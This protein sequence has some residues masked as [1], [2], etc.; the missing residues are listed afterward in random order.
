MNNRI[1]PGNLWQTTYMDG[2]V[3]V[4]RYV[5]E[6]KAMDVKTSYSLKPVKATK[7]WYADNVCRTTFMHKSNTLEVEF[8]SGLVYQYFDVPVILWKRMTEAVSVG[9]FMNIHLK[10]NYRYFRVR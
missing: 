9:S 1:M 6:H 7:N 10:G 8:T 2:S 4:F 3:N 5:E